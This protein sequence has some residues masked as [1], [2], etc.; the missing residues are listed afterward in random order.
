MEDNLI[1]YI[2]IGLILHVATLYLI[3]KFAVSEGLK[4][5]NAIII[6]L[7]Y[8]IARQQGVSD[9]ELNDVNRKLIELTN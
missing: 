2:V 9:E 1:A 7:L 8:K 4:K 5:Q 3:I 6:S